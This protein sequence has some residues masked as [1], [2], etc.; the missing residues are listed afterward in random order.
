MKKKKETRLKYRVV[1]NWS[2]VLSKHALF[3]MVKISLDSSECCSG[4]KK[5]T[6]LLTGFPHNKVKRTKGEAMI[7]KDEITNHTSFVL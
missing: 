5:N 1:E 4:N 3:G 2:S 6:I 7:S